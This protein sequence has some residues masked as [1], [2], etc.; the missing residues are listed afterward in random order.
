MVAMTFFKGEVMEIFK[1]IRFLLKSSIETKS[2]YSAP[3]TSNLTIAKLSDA[4]R[5]SIF[6]AAM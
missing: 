4:T 1:F 3:I 2:D 6:D 5:V